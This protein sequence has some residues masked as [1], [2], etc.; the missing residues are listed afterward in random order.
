MPQHELFPEETKKN[1]LFCKKWLLEEAVGKCLDIRFQESK[2][3]PRLI[4]ELYAHAF[5]NGNETLFK[6]LESRFSANVIQDKEI[7]LHF[8]V[9]NSAE[10]AR[11]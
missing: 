4:A 10:E 2:L 7:H 11:A 5:V 3:F 6:F 9:V 8:E 1:K